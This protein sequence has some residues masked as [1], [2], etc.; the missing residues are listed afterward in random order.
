MQVSIGVP[1][2]SPQEGIRLE[3]DYGFTLEVKLEH[4]EV[5]IRA[6]SAGLISLARHLLVLS[7]PT[8]QV[9]NHIHLD[10]SA[11]LEDNSLALTLEKTSDSAVPA[12]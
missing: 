2:Y 11:S 7:Q 9:G 6:N 1:E 4:G 12:Q 10:P 8:V 3:W 5:V